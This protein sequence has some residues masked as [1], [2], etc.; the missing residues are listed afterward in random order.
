[1]ERQ[2]NRRTRLLLVALLI[3]SSVPAYGEWVEVSVNVEAGQTVYVDPDTIRR[4]GDMVEMWALYDNKTPQPAVGDA[5]L[6][7]KV[8]SEYDCTQEMRRMLSVT[9]FSGNM[10]S[11]KVV[12]MNSSLF[13][14]AKWVPARSGLGE[15]LLKVAC[16]KK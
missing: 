3:L 13:S 8:Q 14:T 16:G 1:L 10:G 15:A 4:K 2:G 11:G 7:R 9:E 5:Y 12:H 6:S